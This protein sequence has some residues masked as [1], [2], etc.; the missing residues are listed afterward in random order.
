MTETLVFTNHA[1]TIRFPE[2][3]WDYAPTGDFYSLT[4]KVYSAPNAF[5][6]FMQTLLFGVKYRKIEQASTKK[7]P[8]KA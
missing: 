4:I 5:H 7:E 3:K 2:P 1:G 6:R 8:V